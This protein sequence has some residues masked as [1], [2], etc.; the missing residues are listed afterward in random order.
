MTRQ[1]GNH[2]RCANMFTSCIQL[3]QYRAYC[4][5]YITAVSDSLN[6]LLLYCVSTLI[7]P[8]NPVITLLAKIIPYDHSMSCSSWHVAQTVASKCELDSSV[9]HVEHVIYNRVMST[10]ST[11]ITVWCIMWHTCYLMLDLKCI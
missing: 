11:I 5:R 8:F 1:I 7:V 3:R 9:D 4:I 10:W 2:G 6:S